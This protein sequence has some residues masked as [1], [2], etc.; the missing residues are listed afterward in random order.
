MLT[1]PH[2][3]MD[4]V[5]LYT[6]VAQAD[7]GQW[8]L[9]RSGDLIPVAEW[10][11]RNLTPAFELLLMPGESQPTTCGWSQLPHQRALDAVRAGQLSRQSKRWHL[12][13]G[14]YIGWSC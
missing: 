4:S 7:A 8:Q 9:E 2:P 5:D 13:L 1:V 12:L 11:L 10:P 6:P 3:N 14:V